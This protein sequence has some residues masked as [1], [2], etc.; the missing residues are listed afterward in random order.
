M[1]TKKAS[2]SVLIP[3]SISAG[4]IKTGTT[5]PVVDTGR[6]EVA[7]SSATAY[8]GVENDINYEGR[9]WASIAPS[10]AGS[11]MPRASSCSRTIRRRRRLGSTEGAGSRGTPPAVVYLPYCILR[12]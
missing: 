4:D 1:S 2:A 10:T 3:N 11:L 8:T 6:G 5:V 9:L 7:W 12:K